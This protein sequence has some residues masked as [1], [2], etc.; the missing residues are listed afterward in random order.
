MWQQDLT[1]LYSLS[2]KQAAGLESLLELLKASRDRGLT[3]VTGDLNIVRFH[4][5]DSLCLLNID[6]LASASSVIDV[7][8]GAGFPGLPLALSRPD[9]HF[10]LLD[11]SSKKCIFLRTA[12]STLAL[13]NVEV[14]NARSEAAASTGLRDSYDAALARAL[15]PL[16]TVIEYTMPFV[17]PGGFAILQRGAG[18]AGDE[19]TASKVAA[20]LSG[21]FIRS[22]PVF[23]YPNA[24][25]LNV[26]VFKKTGATPFRFPRK[27]G[28]ARKRPLR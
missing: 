7:G 14:V 23:P 16:A 2:K 9:I 20:R 3:A 13:Q 4:F 10:T 25:N 6:E 18:R 28:L 21:S 8:S 1:A 24:K 27:A 22:L 12:V 17:Q 15:G 5:Y 11:A 19:E 26:W